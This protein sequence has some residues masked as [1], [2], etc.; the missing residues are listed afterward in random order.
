MYLGPSILELSK[1]IRYE[2]RYDNVKTKYKEKTKLCYMESDSFIVYVETDD[3]QKRRYKRSWSKIWNFKLWIRETITGKNK[4]VIGLMKDELSGEIMNKFVALR[5]KVYSHLADNNDK[6]KKGK[7]TKKWVIKKKLKLKDYKNCLKAT[8]LK[9][10]I[11]PSR[12]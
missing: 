5:A 4:K 1:I 6:D 7:G 11:K 12:K 8:Q 9:N 3:I 2:F 10:K